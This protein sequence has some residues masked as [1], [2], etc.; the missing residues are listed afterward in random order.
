MEWN[1]TFGSAWI[2]CYG[3]IE[4]QSGWCVALVWK[5]RWKWLHHV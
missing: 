3:A 5:L 1:D 2:M 4:K